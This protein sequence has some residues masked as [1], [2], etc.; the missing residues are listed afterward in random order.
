MS[1]RHHKSERNYQKVTNY[2]FHFESSF[3]SFINLNVSK[4]SR[5]KPSKKKIQRQTTIPKKLP[6]NL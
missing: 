4:Y 3:R 2:K 6:F 1:G 5:T